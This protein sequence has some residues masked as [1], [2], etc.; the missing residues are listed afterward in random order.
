MGWIYSWHHLLLCCR[1]IIFQPAA[2]GCRPL[3]K[4]IFLAKHRLCIANLAPLYHLCSERLM[5]C[6]PLPSGHRMGSPEIQ[7]HPT[8]GL[9]G[10]PRASPLGPPA[11][12]CFCEREIIVLHIL[13]VSMRIKW[14]RMLSLASE[15]QQTE[16]GKRLLSDFDSKR[17]TEKAN[18]GWRLGRKQASQM[19]HPCSPE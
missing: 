4:I 7:V 16:R 14:D 2:Q 13:P 12:C 15:W 9:T 8:P 6:M 3:N 18:H 11:C 5:H 19:E 17:E 1:H 10:S